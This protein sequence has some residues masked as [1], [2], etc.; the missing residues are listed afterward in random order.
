MSPRWLDAAWYVLASR[1]AIVI[2]LGIWILLLLVCAWVPQKS[3]VIG[4]EG[5]PV[6]RWLAAVRAE[7][8][9]IGRLLDEL[10]LVRVWDGWVVRV[11]QGFTAGWLALL[12]AGEM[13][14]WLAPASRHVTVRPI[15]M[16]WD[17]ARQRAVEVA[18]AKGWKLLRADE[19]VVVIHACK[20]DAWWRR[21]LVRALW[22]ALLLLAVAWWIGEAAAYQRLTIPLA[23]G[24]ETRVERWGIASMQLKRLQFRPRP[25]GTPSDLAGELAILLSDGTVQRARVI[26]CQVTRVGDVVIHVVGTGP[27]LRLS[28]R[29]SGGEPV[30]LASMSGTG[31]G[32]DVLRV[33]LGGVNQEHLVAVDEGRGTLRLVEGATALPGPWAVLVELLDGYT[34]TSFG[35]EAMQPP[36]TAAF[37]DY[38]VTFAPEYYLE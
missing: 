26:P 19:D 16:A 36:G 4:A 12:A 38:V 14:G 1:W 33:R 30:S 15:E 21:G 24:N 10:G 18:H 29:F 5:Q 22:A 34:G 8:P 13:L 35:R 3:P 6:T 2:V 9:A 31:A 7:R 25:D 17:E 37:D 23:L 28:A 27:V 20:L 11:L 32:A